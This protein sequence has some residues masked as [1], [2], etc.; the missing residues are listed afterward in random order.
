VITRQDNAAVESY[1]LQMA[2]DAKASVWQ[3]LVDSGATP[4]S[5]ETVE[6]VRIASGRPR[7]GQ[8]IRERELPQETE[9]SQALHFSKGC[10]VG[11][12]IV[13]RIRSRGSVHRKFSGFRVEGALPQPGEKIQ[14]DGKDVGEVTS[15]ASLPTAHGEK[16]VA[17]GYVRREFASAGKELMAGS[18]RLSIADLPFHQAW[19]D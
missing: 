5:D 18:A 8:D 13:E 7:Y 4:L 17:L 10:Y 9:Q 6:L 12:E 14:A 19:E 16:L 15:V 1:E 11:Q 3:A 2:P